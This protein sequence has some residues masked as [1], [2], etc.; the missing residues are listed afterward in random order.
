[1]NR[2]FWVLI[3]LILIT[4]ISLLTRAS[5]QEKKSN[6]LGTP[7]DISLLGTP[8]FARILFPEEEA[9]LSRKDKEEIDRVIRKALSAGDVE[10][11]KIL[12][13]ADREYPEE[14]EEVS[15][16][17]IKLAEDRSQVIEK[18]VQERLRIPSTERF[19]MARRPG[20]ISEALKTP[21]ARFKKQAEAE[22]L[23]PSTLESSVFN[24][25]HRRSSTALVLVELEE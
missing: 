11:V 4:S 21:E 24:K 12:A 8:F 2:R 3:S 17:D 10:S 13:W 14:S 5:S 22:G 9:E 7:N 23:A 19:N 6:I 1:M 15:S 25:I 20:R 16:K 18:Y